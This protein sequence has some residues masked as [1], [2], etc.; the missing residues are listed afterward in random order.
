MFKLFSRWNYF[1]VRFFV[2]TF[3]DFFEVVR[4]FLRFLL[5]LDLDLDG[6]MN[7]ILRDRFMAYLRIVFWSD[8]CFF[9]IFLE[10]LKDLMYLF[11]EPLYFWKRFLTITACCGEWK[12]MR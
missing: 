8:F 1:L 11:H 12:T 9:S 7:G 10:D 2:D 4:V 3:L 5:D 6:F